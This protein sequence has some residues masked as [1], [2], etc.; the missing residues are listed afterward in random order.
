MWR[1]MRGYG[2]EDETNRRAN[3]SWK[4]RVL[5]LA[6]CILLACYHPFYG[7]AERPNLSFA[8]WTSTPCSVWPLT[9]YYPL[10][11]RSYPPLLFSAVSITHKCWTPRNLNQLLIY[12]Y[13]W[14]NES[15]PT[16][17]LA[18]GNKN[19]SQI[20]V[21]NL[22]FFYD[23]IIDVIQWVATS[24]CLGTFVRKVVW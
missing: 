17:T 8:K 7:H 24:I 19:Q 2:S 15:E 22:K 14:R 1:H 18:R 16:T 12:K 3:T 13:I 23:Y 9:L 21:S 10:R 11:Q 20:R 6:T 4:D 5:W